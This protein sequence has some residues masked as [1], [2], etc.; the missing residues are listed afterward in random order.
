MNQANVRAD[1]AIVGAGLAGL[2]AARELRAAGASV[3][4]LEARD[5]VG[6]RTASEV[7]D[8]VVLDMGAQW[9]GP[10]SAA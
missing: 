4:V 10:G 1:V 6:G 5:R 7:I 9:F 2:T 3:L 8:G